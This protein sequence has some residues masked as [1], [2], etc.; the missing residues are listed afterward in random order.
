MDS[1]LAS[2]Q[3]SAWLKELQ[4]LPAND[5]GEANVLDHRRKL[6]DVVAATSPQRDYLQELLD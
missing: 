1:R 2:P 3:L 4:A 5:S 6:E